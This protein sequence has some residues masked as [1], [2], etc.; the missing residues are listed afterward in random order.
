MTLKTKTCTLCNVRYQGRNKNGNDVYCVIC[1]QIALTARRM[2]KD[3]ELAIKRTG[4]AGSNRT[5]TE[6]AALDCFAEL[7]PEAKLGICIRIHALREEFRIAGAT[8]IGAVWVLL[9][10]FECMQ[11]SL[12]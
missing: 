12:I 6:Q 9:L 11:R 8:G 1:S 2:M 10:L 5:P 3:I 4:T 7:S